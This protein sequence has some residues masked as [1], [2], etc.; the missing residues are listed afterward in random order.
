MTA[1]SPLEHIKQA[2][3]TAGGEWSW[4]ERLEA[5]RA[6]GW[7][8]VMAGPQEEIRFDQGDRDGTDSDR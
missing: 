3:A 1:K 4:D 2:R 7:G 6:L 8:E 5:A